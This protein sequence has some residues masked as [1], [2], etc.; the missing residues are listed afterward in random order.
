MKSIFDNATRG[1]LIERIE[2][3]TPGNRAQWGKMNLIQMLK[4]CILWEEMVAG[5]KKHK[6]IFLGYFFGKM[7]LKEMIGNENDL[8]DGIPTIPGLVVNETQGDIELE[9]RRWITL[10]LENADSPNANFVHP[11]CGKMTIEQIG[12]L[13][14]KHNDHHLRQFN[15]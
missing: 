13:S 9:K 5:K 12:Y 1:I 7:A 11:F 14:F 15:V 10:I 3:L 2:S 6:R 4:H 8:K